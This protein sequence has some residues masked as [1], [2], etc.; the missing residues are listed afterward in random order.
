[1][2]DARSYAYE[3]SGTLTFAHFGV[4]SINSSDDI[5]EEAGPKRASLLTKRVALRRDLA[6]P[7]D[8]MKKIVNPNAENRSG[9]GSGSP[10]HRTFLGRFARREVPGP[11]I[12]VLASD[13]A[14]HIKRQQAACGQAASSLEG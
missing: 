4:W 8:R 11:A 12:V 10:R 13:A 7:T 1:L 6:Q 9:G 2:K 14:A 3:K 5:I